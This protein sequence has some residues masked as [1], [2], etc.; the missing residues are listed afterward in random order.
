MFGELL[1]FSFTKNYHHNLCASA[2]T[3]VSKASITTPTCHQGALCRALLHEHHVLEQRTVG[4][5]PA[6]SGYGLGQVGGQVAAGEEGRAEG[7]GRL[8]TSILLCRSHLERRGEHNRSQTAHTRTHRQI[9]RGGFPPYVGRSGGRGG[10]GQ[11]QG[12]VGQRWRSVEGQ[13]VNAAPLSTAAQPL[14]QRRLGSTF[15]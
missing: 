6:R 15:K 12:D 8:Q 5:V 1:F 3:G 4:A 11:P 14:G 9:G 13:L 7:E 2:F 10:G